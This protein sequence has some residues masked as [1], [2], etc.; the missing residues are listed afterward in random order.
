MSDSV[1]LVPSVPVLT[2]VPPVRP[3]HVVEPAKDTQADNR[4]SNEHRNSAQQDGPTNRHL[5]I[6]RND[7]LNTFVYRSID[8]DSGDVIW[9]YPAE[10]ILRMSQHQRELERQEREH[11]VDEK[12]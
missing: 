12:A 9:Q 7:T 2:R 6:S 10:N 3:D 4:E 11:K 5:T 1:Q 8:K